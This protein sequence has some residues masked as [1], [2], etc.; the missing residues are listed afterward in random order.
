MFNQGIRRAQE[1]L[2][3]N[4]NEEAVFNVSKLTVFE[5]NIFSTVDD[6]TQGDN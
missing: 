3:E 2:R 4:N 1:M 5:V 6:V